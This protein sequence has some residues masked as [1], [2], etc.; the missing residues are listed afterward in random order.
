MIVVGLLS[1]KFSIKYIFTDDL[2]NVKTFCLSSEDSN[3]RITL[4]SR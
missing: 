2:A 3:Y 4:G 1:D